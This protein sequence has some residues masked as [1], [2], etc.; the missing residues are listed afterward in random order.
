MTRLSADMVVRDV[1]RGSRWT[2]L[3]DTLD[4]AIISRDGSR[5]VTLG[6]TG[7]TAWNLDAPGEGTVLSTDATYAAAIS[8]DGGRVVA[9]GYWGLR[10][11]DTDGAVEGR[12]LSDLDTRSVAISQD[13][14]TVVSTSLDGDAV[15]W[16]LDGGSDPVQLTADQAFSVLLSDDGTVAVTKGG[17]GVVVHWI[18]TGESVT[19]DDRAGLGVAINADGSRIVTT[20]LTSVK[21]WS[22]GSA[23]TAVAINT[24]GDTLVATAIDPSGAR[25]VVVGQA[26]TT[27]WSADGQRIAILSRD[28]LSSA[29]FSGDGSRIIGVGPTGVRIWKVSSTEMRAEVDRRVGSHTF[30][31]QECTV[32][33][34]EPCPA[35]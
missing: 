34:I 5:A 23:P 16:D 13:G 4:A 19:L 9:G 14:S 22:M 33:R 1:D 21:V 15:V 31:D 26:G 28:T 8:A 10:V 25:I 29:E 7:V 27:L 30:S 11:W 35:G 3:T 2:L 17:S 24:V 12:V 20:D 32:Y 6:D 18:E